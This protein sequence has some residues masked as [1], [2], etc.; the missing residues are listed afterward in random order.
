MTVPNAEWPRR[1][2]PPPNFSWTRYPKKG[3]CPNSRGSAAIPE[4]ETAMMIDIRKPSA[5]KA[6]TGQASSG[7]AA[8]LFAR[9]AGF[10]SSPRLGMSLS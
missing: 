9:I 3:N 8:A 7:V 4:L 2:E 10:G 6:T 1:P 5:Q